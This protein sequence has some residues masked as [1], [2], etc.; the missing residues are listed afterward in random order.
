[1]WVGLRKHDRDLFL[2]GLLV[3]SA[4]G[5]A[6]LAK[7]FQGKGLWFFVAGAI[8]LLNQD[9][10]ARNVARKTRFM[11]KSLPQKVREKVSSE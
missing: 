2:L 4:F 8:V 5:A 1:M 3:T 7:E 10:M 9:E 11:L 6:L